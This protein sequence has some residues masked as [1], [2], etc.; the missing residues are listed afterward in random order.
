MIDAYD[1][2]EAHE[3]RLEREL[4]A[5][6]VCCCCDEPI[7]DDHFYHIDGEDYCPDCL[8]CFRRDNLWA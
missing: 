6:P 4:A 2:W 7:Q 1:L 8:D 3:R 5:L